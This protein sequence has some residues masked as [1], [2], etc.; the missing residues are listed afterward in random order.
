MKLRHIDKSCGQ[1]PLEYT[2]LT[3]Y[4]NPFNRLE[5]LSVYLHLFQSVF[6]QANASLRHHY[7]D[8]WWGFKYGARL[9]LSTLDTPWQDWPTMRSVIFRFHG[10][11]FITCYSQ[12]F[13]SFKFYLTPFQ[14]LIWG[15]LVGSVVIVSV[16]L[17]LF[18]KFKNAYQNFSPWLFVLANIF[19]ET[20]HVPRHLGK[21]HFF[22]LVIGSWVLMSVILTNCYNGL[23]ISSLNAPLPKT[24]IPETFQDLIC[25][26]KHILKKYKEG[27]N[28]TDWV[29]TTNEEIIRHFFKPRNSTV[30]YKI[31]SVGST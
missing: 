16:V 9:G 7:E 30:C 1:G 18:K 29:L 21:Q 13:I 27:A 22:R 26:D 25:K 10:H 17:S 19:E 6:R 28:L 23:M 20:G 15:A 5:N 8:E 14:P 12:T 24:D 11:R 2:K 31:L 4:S 3:F